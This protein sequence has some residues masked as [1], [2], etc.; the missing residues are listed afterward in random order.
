[1]ATIELVFTPIRPLSNSTGSAPDSVIGAYHQFLL[2]TNDAGR[3]FYLRAGPSGIVNEQSGHGNIVLNG[4][5]YVLGTRDYPDTVAEFNSWY[6]AP[7]RLGGAAAAHRGREGPSGRHRQAAA[8]R[9]RPAL[10]R[11]A[12]P[13]DRE[14]E[15][16]APR[17]R[18]GG[19]EGCGGRAGD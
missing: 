5:A 8:G 2:Y 6:K 3:R 1:M 16:L 19:R 4:G 12:A 10:G 18:R 7:A 14:R 13:A 17:A 9:R 11:A 15:H